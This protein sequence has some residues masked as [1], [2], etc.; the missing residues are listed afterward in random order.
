MIKEV[1]KKYIQG[2]EKTLTSI[3]SDQTEE[4]VEEIIKVNR[5]FVFGAGRSGLVGKAFAM[6]LM[7]LGLEVFFIGET[8]TPSI[9]K[10]DGIFFVS[11]SGNTLSVVNMIK[12][13]KDKGVK[14]FGLT[15]QKDGFL[16]Q[17]ADNVVYIDTENIETSGDYLT[18]QIMGSYR[19]VAPLGTTFESAALVYLDSL[20]VLLMAKLNK[21]EE[22]LRLKHANIE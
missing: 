12:A 8:V 21:T 6:R 10:D 17:N 20:V 3:D 13:S 7:H 16:F 18:M 2:L 5:I 14:V 22:D 15:A 9:E 19:K 1:I 11:G 4:L